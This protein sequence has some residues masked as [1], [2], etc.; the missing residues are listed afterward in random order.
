MLKNLVV[1]SAL[2]FCSVAA[3]HA[4]PITGSFSVYGNN[5]VTFDST[6]NT[7][8]VDFGPTTV[9][10]AI[11]GT[12]ASY[13]QDGNTVTFLPG[14]LPFKTGTNTP[15]SSVYPSGYVPIFSV[16]GNS[17]EKFTF[18]MTSYS[19]TPTSCSLECLNVSI[20]GYLSA[21]GPVSLMNSGPANGATTFQF[22]A[23]DSTASG[24]PDTFSGEVVAPT[25]EPE[26]LA[27][28]GTGLLG[29][30]GV[31]RRKFSV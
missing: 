4:D 26:S 20:Y 11:N 21:T 1:L 29:I 24:F 31:A 8:S 28:L 27:L 9:S 13:L 6:T 3:A 18:D 19:V 17:G 22:L 15:P 2:A 10:G 7:G 5:K 30:F 25:P 23:S 16:T 12:F 14:A